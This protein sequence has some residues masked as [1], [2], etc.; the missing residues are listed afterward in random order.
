MKDIEITKATNYVSEKNKEIQNHPLRQKYHFEVPSGWCNDPNGFSFYNGKYQLF[1]QHMPYNAEPADFKMYWGHAQSMDLVNWENLPIA[2][3]PT[4][5]YDGGG[6]WSGCAFEKEGNLYAMYTGLD[7][8]NNNQQGQCMAI[9]KDGIY[10]EKVNENPILA[11]TLCDADKKDF[12]DPG[13]WW[14]NN[15][16]NMIVG[17]TKNKFGQALLYRSDDLKS[18]RFINVLAESLGDLGSVCECPNFFEMEGKHV[19]FISPHGLQERKSVYLVGD[20]D[21]PSGKFNW[22]NYGEIDWGMD[23]YAPQVLTDSQGR[24][25][26]MG[27]MNSWDW[28]PWSNGT[29]YTADLGWCGG[30][31]LPRK[32]SFDKVNRIRFEPVEELKQ[33]RSK[34][35]FQERNLCV[36]NGQAYP[37]V[38]KDNVHCEILMKF[39]LEETSADSICL[40]LRSND[41]HKVEISFDIKKGEIIFDRTK[42]LDG[43]NGIRKCNFK[44]ASAK[45]C[46]VHLFLDSSSIEFFTDDYTTCMSNNVYLP[47]NAE[48]I[49]LHSRGGKV[50]ISEC[51]IWS[52]RKEA[53]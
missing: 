30:M 22:Y 40:E 26:A 9:S 2:L 10:F 23:Y 31:A 52:L 25:I 13:I 20:F 5:E 35:V 39:N 43:K 41:V 37:I 7:A 29:Y 16:W 45:E 44:M 32:L 38:T 21:Y 47:E 36:E 19:L 12:R 53:I 49:A 3:A 4:A 51:T 14:E 28:M 27:W 48:G 17:S 42:T 6:C 18:W 1:Y 46:Q 33:L 50:I 11:E 15:E 34:T 24:K 8:R